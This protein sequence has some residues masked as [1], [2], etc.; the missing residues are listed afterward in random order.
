MATVTESL[1]EPTALAVPPDHLYELIDGVYV[2]KKVGADEIWTANVLHACIALYLR[3]H[4]IGRGAVE[5]IFQMEPQTNRLRRPDYAFVSAERFPLEQRKLGT[6]WKVVP[7]LVAEV[8]SPN[9]TYHEVFEKVEEYFRVGVRLVWL[10]SHQM[11]TVQ[12]YASPMNVRVLKGNDTLDGGEVLPGFQL[13][14]NE[15]FGESG[16]D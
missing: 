11:A 2:E 7:D 15:L 14:L 6:V 16:K 3:E 8:I 12:V 5:M 10:I 4:R 1:L 9:D 13:A